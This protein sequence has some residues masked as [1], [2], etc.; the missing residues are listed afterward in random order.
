MPS[1]SLAAGPDGSR[2]RL[3]PAAIDSIEKADAALAAAGGDRLRVEK[4]YKATARE[5]LKKFLVSDC[6]EEAKM[7]RRDQLADIEAAQIEANRYKRR[8]KAD[9][10]EAERAKRE[11]D[12]A[13]VDGD[14]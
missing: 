3:P 1:A 4:E 11:A 12:R 8:A 14:P 2:D 9:R 6:I 10:L 13:V 7:L 5:C